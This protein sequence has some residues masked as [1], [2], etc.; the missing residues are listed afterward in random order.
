MLQRSLDFPYI[1]LELS[2]TARPS[3]QTLVNS[4]IAWTSWQIVDIRPQI[5]IRIRHQTLII[6]L[7]QEYYDQQK[8]SEHRG[9]PDLI[10]LIK[11]LDQHDY[12]SNIRSH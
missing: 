2:M 8:I 1:F 7:H 12:F 10:N 4:F 11:E 5:T 6:I 9:E 3:H